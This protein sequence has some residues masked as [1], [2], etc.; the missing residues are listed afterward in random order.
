MPR[1]RMAA[2]EP[3][4]GAPKRAASSYTGPRRPTRSHSIRGRW[5]Q[6]EMSVTSIRVGASRPA[7]PSLLPLAFIAGLVGLSTAQ[8]IAA[9]PV[10]EATLLTTA[11]LLGLWYVALVMRSR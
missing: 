4:G 3:I 6:T 1:T 2:L 11:A 7:R 10:L 8:R 5:R 9:F